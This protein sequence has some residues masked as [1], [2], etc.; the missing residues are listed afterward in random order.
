M[1]YY[2][3]DDCFVDFCECTLRGILVFVFDHVVSLDCTFLYALQSQNIPGC[4]EMTKPVNSLLHLVLVVQ[5]LSYLSLNLVFDGEISSLHTPS[6]HTSLFPNTFSK[7]CVFPLF[8][9]SFPWCSWKHIP[10]P[11]CHFPSFNLLPETL[12]GSYIPFL[13]SSCTQHLSSCMLHIFRLPSAQS[14]WIH[15]SRSTF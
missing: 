15:R 10:L 5:V 13:C 3:S 2:S 7:H 12:L 1:V 6:L 8:S 9:I 4:T 14:L 11:Q